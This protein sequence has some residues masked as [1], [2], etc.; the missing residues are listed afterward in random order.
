MHAVY[1]I[2]YVF[3]HEMQCQGTCFMEICYSFRA[4]RI[5]VLKQT[6]VYQPSTKSDK[7]LYTDSLC[8]HKIIH[9]NYTWLVLKRAKIFKTK[10]YEKMV[11]Y[12]A[13]KH[14]AIKHKR[15]I[16]DIIY[17]QSV[18]WY[19]SDLWLDSQY[20][21]SSFS[22]FISLVVYIDRRQIDISVWRESV[23]HTVLCWGSG[24]AVTTRCWQNQGQIFNPLAHRMFL[25][26]EISLV[27]MRSIHKLCYSKKNN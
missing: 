23:R 14:C 7:F 5:C 6:I 20:W 4:D 2:I 15:L 25:S 1:L 13:V 16:H 12:K 22:V 11:S 18:C 26:P 9:A 8:H 3:I 21:F 10:K 24:Q 19:N 17:T 27:T